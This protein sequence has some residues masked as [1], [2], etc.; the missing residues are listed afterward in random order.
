MSLSVAIGLGLAPA[1]A[2]GSVAGFLF[3]G[4]SRSCW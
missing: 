4:C 2:L 3:K 1:T